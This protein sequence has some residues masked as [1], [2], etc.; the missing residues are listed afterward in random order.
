[1]LLA[2][3]TLWYLPKLI[4]A[5]FLSLFTIKLNNYRIFICSKLGLEAIACN[6]DWW[7]RQQ[8]MTNWGFDNKRYSLPCSLYLCLV[9]FVTLSLFFSLLLYLSPSLSTSSCVYV[10]TSPSHSLSFF[11]LISISQSLF[12]SFYLYELSL[13]LSPSLNS[14]SSL[15]DYFF[16]NLLIV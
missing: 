12:T 6:G 4:W 8:A 10:L 13:A 9:L 3:Q 11:L 7:T 16:N 1:M 14:V 5:K 15:L 2:V